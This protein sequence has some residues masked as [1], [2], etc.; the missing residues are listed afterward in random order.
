MPWT[1]LHHKPISYGSPSADFAFWFLVVLHVIPAAVAPIAAIVAFRARKGEA[2][3]LLAGK[4]FVWAMA[5]LAVTGIVIDVIRLSWFVDENHTKYAGYAMPS[6]YPA[7]LGFLYAGLCV[8]YMLRE[9]T[10]PRVFRAARTGPSVFD[11]WAPRVLLALGAL[12]FCLI[13]V[14][15]NPWTGALWMIVTF[16]ALVFLVGRG[17]TSLTTRAQGVAHHRFGMAF[18]AAF[19][20][21]GALQGFGPAI[22]VAI[23]GADPSTLPYLGNRP[24]SFSPFIFLFLVAWA[25]CFG[26]AAWLVRRFRRRSVEATPS[27]LGN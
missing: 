22:G 21:W 25:P 13:V 18:L 19:S 8:L 15:Y 2:L 27:A 24:G 16:A 4:L 10:P 1:P 11:V 9:A 6:T 5:A 14:R 3:H 12:L 7:R 23:K 26:L 20:W 17:R